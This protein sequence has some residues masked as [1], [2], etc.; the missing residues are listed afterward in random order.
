MDWS[1]RNVLV[2]TFVEQDFAMV[3]VNIGV[4]CGV[5]GRDKRHH[6]STQ[7]VVIFAQTRPHSHSITF[8]HSVEIFRRERMGSYLLARRLLFLGRSRFIFQYYIQ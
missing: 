8:L 1:D 3:D 6:I 5:V 4:I 2:R 7:R